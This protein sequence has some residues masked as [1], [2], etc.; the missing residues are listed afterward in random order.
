MLGA[1]FVFLIGCLV[2]C[3]VL[4]VISLVMEMITLPD[5]IKKIALV[6]IGLIGL[7]VL[8]MLAVNVFQGG[9]GVVVR[10]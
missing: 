2:L 7:V 1:L 6:I 4:Y 9:V 5:Q 3:A 10:W 8:L